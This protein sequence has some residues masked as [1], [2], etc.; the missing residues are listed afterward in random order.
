MAT[1][2]APLDKEADRYTRRS[3]LRSERMY[4]EGFQSP[5]N[6]AAVAS[7]CAR[8]ELKPRMRI[9]DIGSGLGGSAFYLADRYDACVVGLDVAPAMVELSTERARERNLSTVVFQLG[10]IRNHPLSADAFDLAWTRDAIL[11]V[12]EKRM[13]WR[14]VFNSLK[15]GGQLFITDF[16]RRRGDLSADFSAYVEQCHYHLQDVGEYTDTLSQAGFEIATAEDVTSNFIDSL[17]KEREDLIRHKAEF[18]ADFEEA[19]YRYLV[20]RWE[21]KTRFSRQ[22]DLRWGLFVARKP[23]SNSAPAVASEEAR[24]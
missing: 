13:V 16:C 3:I 9:L 2:T 20:E 4:G 18:L 10:D 15:P 19:D 17:E 7:F 14:R 5:G 23:Q 6:I 21:M 1:A 11:Y 12:P 22:G 24:P 8:L